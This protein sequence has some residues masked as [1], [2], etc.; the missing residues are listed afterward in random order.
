MCKANKIIFPGVG[1]FSAGVSAIKELNLFDYLKQTSKP[2]LG[3]CLGM[4]LFFEESEESPGV[5][6][7]SII[8]GKIEK[9]RNNQKIP[10]I[11]WA[12]T[13]VNNDFLNK[14][15]NDIMSL[16]YMHSFVA[17]PANKNEIVMKSDDLVV[18]VKKNN[19]FGL[20]CHPEKSQKDGL[21]LI[22]GFCNLI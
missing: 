17:N 20:Q 12:D 18:G 4:Q 19:I 16:Y 21:D 6:G 14:K 10:R 1:F 8:K 2:M 22:S 15:T 11:G 13:V 5:L 9:I 3:I 7:L